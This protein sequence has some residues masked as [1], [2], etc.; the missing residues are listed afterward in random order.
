MASTSVRRETGLEELS[1]QVKELQARIGLIEKKIGIG[2]EQQ[3]AAAEAVPLAEAEAVVEETLAETAS[4]AP[5]FGKA[6]LGLAGAYLLRALTEMERLPVS[7][8]LALGILYAGAWLVMAARASP[9]D[10][11]TCTV[12]GLTSVL[13]VVPLLWEAH[14]RFHAL[15]PWVTASV[16]VMFS[17]FGLAVAWR[18]DI[19]SIAWITTLAGLATAS[20][21]LVA[22]EDLLPFTWAIFGMAF[23]VEVSAC[24]EHWLKER[25]IGAVAADLAVL[26]L[27]LLV[28]R[29]GGLPESYAPIDRGAALAVQVA[30]LGLYL[31]ST[32][33]R[34]LWRGFTITPFEIAQCV[35]A[36]LIST[37]GAIRVAEGHPAAVLTVG[38]VCVAGGIICYGVSFAFLAP[39]SRTDRNF[40]TYATFGLMLALTGSRLVLSGT[41]LVVLLSLL[42]VVSVGV[43]RG[44]GRLMLKWHGAAY[45]FLALVTS[46]FAGGVATRFLGGA[47]SNAGLPGP[48]AWIIMSAAV[49]TYG[50]VWLSKAPEGGLWNYRMLAALFALAAGWSIAGVAAGVFSPQCQNGANGTATPDF[51]PTVLTA[52]LTVMAVSLAWATKRWPRPEL[53]WTAYLFIAVATYKLVIQDFRQGETLAIVISLV[54][55]GS[56]LVL[57]P[58]FL[59][60]P[61]H[62]VS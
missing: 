48:T 60:R 35:A 34:T 6:L 47:H 18:R 9:D 43:G 28:T 39:H 45:L 36:F 2:A 12:R 52:I 22:T 42:A 1:R 56:A 61:K 50:L 11:P 4:L 49:I 30:L 23:A 7:V 19:S 51:C 3:A 24:M 57:L 46:G 25:W 62:A 29:Q 33:A 38:L 32:Y 41:A 58:R 55:Y 37:W 17:V 53:T 26:V 16:L 40:Y 5:L 21:L 10:T 13:V 20:A 15:S 8:G 31:A 44:S 59:Q 27:T 14:M 54:L